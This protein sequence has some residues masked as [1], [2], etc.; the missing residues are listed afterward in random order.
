MLFRSFR[1]FLVTAVSGSA[2]AWVLDL[3]A[4]MVDSTGTSVAAG[5]FVSPASVNLDGYAA[6]ILDMFESLAP[7]E[8]TTDVNRLPRAARHPLAAD[9]VPEDLTDYLLQGHFKK[10]PEIT[11]LAITHAPTS[12]PTVPGSV[13]TAPNVLVPRHFGIY[14]F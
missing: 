11:N 1:V 9:D 6:S 3:D 2:G 12:T 13:D 14:P 8:N 5:E 7:G 4:P 10:H